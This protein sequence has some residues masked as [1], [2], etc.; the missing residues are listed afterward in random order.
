MLSC[1]QKIRLKSTE[2]GSNLISCQR[3]KALSKVWD[4]SNTISSCQNLIR[5]DRTILNALSGCSEALNDGWANQTREQGKNCFRRYRTWTELDSKL[6][7]LR[8]SQVHTTISDFTQ[9]VLR[10]KIFIVEF[11]LTSTGLN[12][13]HFF[14]VS[15]CILSHSI[16]Y[17]SNQC[18]IYEVYTLKH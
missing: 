7:K 8:L 4:S 12:C 16:F 6:L 1:N 2:W 11:L 14:T 18:T 15:P 13:L 10:F 9:R 5:H 17:C 3:S